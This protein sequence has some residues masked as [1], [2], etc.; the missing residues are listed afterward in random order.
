MPLDVRGL[1]P[2]TLDGLLPR[3]FIALDLKG[4][5]V[6]VVGH[7]VYWMKRGKG[8]TLVLETY[9]GAIRRIPRGSIEHVYYAPAGWRPR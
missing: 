5:V 6:P 9:D 7:F 8:Q 4:E 2:T 3:V 1:E